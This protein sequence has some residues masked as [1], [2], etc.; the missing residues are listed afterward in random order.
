MERETMAR[1]K[2]PLAE[3]RE[4][5][6][7]LHYEITMFYAAAEGLRCGL[8]GPG[9]L[10]NVLVESFAVH[11]RNLIDFLYAAQPRTDDVVAEDFVADV[12][13]WPLIRPV[14]SDVLLRAKRRADKEIAHLTYTRLA[15]TDDAKPW[16]F[17]EIFGQIVPVFELFME[18]VEGERLDKVWR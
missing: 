11:V 17:V 5:S 6:K 14:M 15:V 7:H 13:Q 8:F 10:S 1:N 18:N 12:V 16:P 9:P 4:A 2:R 3:L